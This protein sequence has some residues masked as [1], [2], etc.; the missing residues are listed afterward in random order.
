MAFAICSRAWLVGGV[1]IVA[2]QGTCV[3]ICSTNMEL[4][5]YTEDVIC[6]DGEGGR[7]RC[8][9]RLDGPRGLQNTIKD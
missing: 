2:D 5:T 1:E 8:Q 9:R 3:S 4:G 7:W 6:R